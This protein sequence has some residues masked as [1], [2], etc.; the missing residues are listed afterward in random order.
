RVLKCP[1]GFTKVRYQGRANNTAQLMTLF[2][3]SNVGM[4]RGMLL[5]RAKA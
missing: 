4:V 2:A 5:N 1:F 3:L